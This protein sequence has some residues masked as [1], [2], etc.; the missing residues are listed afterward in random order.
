MNRDSS[1]YIKDILNCIQNI[2]DFIAEMSY[3]EF[4]SDIKT[5]SAV[6][7]QLEIIGEASKNI[8]SDMRHQY[9][10]VPWSDM[11]RMRDKLIHFYFGVDYEIVWKVIRLQLPKIKE[12][13]S[14]PHL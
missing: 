14:K 1:L 4:A 5:S 11:A 3:D 2:E 12:S 13:F 9:E 10:N 8:P 7:R 6:I